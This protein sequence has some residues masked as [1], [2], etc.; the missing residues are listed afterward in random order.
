MWL[1]LLLVDEVLAG[2]SS[3]FTNVSAASS[4]ASPDLN[5]I[6]LIDK[7]GLAK[8]ARVFIEQEVIVF[9]SLDACDYL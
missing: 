3:A 9:L 4:M 6:E 1:L 5:L 2:K 8:Y 7:L